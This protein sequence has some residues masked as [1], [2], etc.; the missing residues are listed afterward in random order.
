MLRDQWVEILSHNNSAILL[1]CH[2][3]AVMMVNHYSS[4][5]D[6][7][8]SCGMNVASKLFENNINMIALSLS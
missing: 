5:N 7:A 8:L 4:W 1:D 6:P 2:S 3:Q